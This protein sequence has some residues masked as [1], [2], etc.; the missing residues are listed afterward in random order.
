MKKNA[1]HRT[2]RQTA[3]CRWHARI[4]A[5]KVGQSKKTGRSGSAGSKRASA[6]A[7]RQWQRLTTAKITKR[8]AHDN[9]HQRTRSKTRPTACR[10]RC[11]QP[12]TCR[13]HDG[14]DAGAAAGHADRIGKRICTETSVLREITHIRGRHASGNTTDAGG[15][16]A[17]VPTAAIGAR[18]ICWPL[19]AVISLSSY[20]QKSSRACRASSQACRRWTSSQSGKLVISS[21]L[22][23]GLRLGGQ[24]GRIPQ[25]LPGHIRPQPF[26]AHAGHALNQWA[27]VCWCFA[28]AVT[29]KTNCLR[30]NPK[31]FRQLCDAAGDGNGFLNWFHAVYSTHVERTNLH[32]CLI[33]FQH[34]FSLAKWL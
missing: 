18:T 9:Q 12:G 27:F 25:H 13:H 21:P 23:C 11:N 20:S 19:N 7:G 6:P 5:W 1:T 33:Y 30:R 28:P 17:R 14:A 22:L 16:R 2:A 3:A 34:L 15:R 24:L 8:G 29:P 26:T 32:L 31:L 10:P 4:R